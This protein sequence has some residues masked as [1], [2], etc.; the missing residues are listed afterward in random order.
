MKMYGISDKS[1]TRPKFTNDASPFSA[2]RYRG[3]P[4]NP[5]QTLVTGGED[6]SWTGDA[7]VSVSADEANYK[8]GVQAIKLTTTGAATGYAYV[9]PVVPTAG[10]AGDAAAIDPLPCKPAQAICG[11]VYID[12]ATRLTS[13]AFLMYTASGLGTSVSKVVTT[14]WSN[15]WNFVRAS[16]TSSAG[17]DTMSNGIYRLTIRVISTDAINVTIGHLYLE[18]PRKARVILACDSSYETFCQLAWPEF[19]RRGWPTTWALCPSR[20][21][22]QGLIG[23]KLKAVV[24]LSAFRAMMD[25]DVAGDEVSIHS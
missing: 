5:I 15:G 16:F 11:W 12:D 9:D 1:V 19:Q 13:L 17:L 22:Y 7:N 2:K 14:G 10:I 18:H 23:G 20:F 24:G 8:W 6:E 4:V 21:G 25:A 3:M